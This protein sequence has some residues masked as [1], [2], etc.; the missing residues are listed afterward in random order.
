MLLSNHK[1][2]AWKETVPLQGDEVQAARPR[3]QGGLGQLGAQ[4]AEQRDRLLADPPGDQPRGGRL[5]ENRKFRM[6]C[7]RL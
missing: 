3:E 5:Q 6:G 2:S 4:K 7:P 1:V